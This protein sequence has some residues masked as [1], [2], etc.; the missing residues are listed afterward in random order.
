MSDQGAP[1]AAPD[2]TPASAPSDS[3]APP[4]NDNAGNPASA[5]AKT[6]NARRAEIRA[7]LS[8]PSKESS[9]TK[10]TADA[11]T[12]KSAEPLSAASP[13]DG[14][15]IAALIREQRR[16]TAESKQLEASRAQ[17]KEFE[18]DVQRAKAAREALKTGNRIG[19]L[20]ALFPDEDLTSDLFWDLAKAVGEEPE[21]AE[22]D[23]EK[24]VAAQVE[25]KMK[26]DAE[27]AAKRRQDEK[28]AH[29]ARLQSAH[30]EYV[31]AV[32]DVFS[33]NRDKFPAINA[34]GIGAERI[35]AFVEDEYHP[36]NGTVPSPFETLQHLE[37]ELTSRIRSTPYAAREAAP[38]PP[39][40]TLSSAWR[41]DPGRPAN[42]NHAADSI[43]QIRAR[44][45]ASFRAGAR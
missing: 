28:D 38:P 30:S 7:K 9:A 5:A 27:A 24:L 13:P 37:D 22:P 6:L 23:I 20:K 31:G 4:A 42:D 29:V 15:E 11:T 44:I 36:K 16:L 17:L 21:A 19:A 26:A 8:N 40:A 1:S 25:A 2:A 14:D 45:K 32:G 12:A 34:L 33:A 10:E 35:R 3:G 41:S 18:A 39:A 43:E